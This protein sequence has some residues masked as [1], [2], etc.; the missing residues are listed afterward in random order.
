MNI[1]QKLHFK[2]LQ[3]HGS[4]FL[5]GGFSFRP[6]DFYKTTISSGAIL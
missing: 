3:R 6:N 4:F 1:S 2:K 5:A